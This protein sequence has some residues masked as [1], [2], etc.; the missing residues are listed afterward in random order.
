MALESGEEILQVVVECSGSKGTA[1][2][3][4]ERQ[5]VQ[6]VDMRNIE[7]LVRISRMLSVFS[8]TRRN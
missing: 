1:S 5:P 7:E 8:E 2:D 6:E 4:K 3:A